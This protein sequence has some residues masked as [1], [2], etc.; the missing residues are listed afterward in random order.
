MLL[1]AFCYACSLPVTWQRWRTHD[2]I[3]HIRKPPVTRKL[4][5]FV[6]YKGVLLTIEVCG[7]RD[8]RPFCSCDLDIDAMTFIYTEFQKSDAKIQI[9]ITTAYLI[10]IKYPLSSF[11]YHLSDV[12]VANFNKIHRH[13]FGTQW[14]WP[15]F[16]GDTPENFLRQGVR[17]LS[18][19]IHIYIHTYRPRQTDRQ[20]GPKLYTTPLRGCTT[21]TEPGKDH[22]RVHH[23]AHIGPQI[24]K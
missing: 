18:S 5:G 13:F 16:S 14:N 9:T 24:Y 22:C 4:Y 10:R 7:N 1:L 19:D 8:F 15:A 23:E 6:F 2:S 17:K 12:N 11:T 20:T 3:R 21:K